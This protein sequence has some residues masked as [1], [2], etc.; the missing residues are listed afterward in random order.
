MTKPFEQF[1]ACTPSLPALS[2]PQ[3]SPSEALLQLDV[4]AATSERHAKPA[5]QKKEAST[6]GPLANYPAIPLPSNRARVKALRARHA[7]SFRAF[8]GSVA[9]DLGSS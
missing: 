3:R 8:R 5:L 6:K 4:N 2:E 1:G 7:L 9:I